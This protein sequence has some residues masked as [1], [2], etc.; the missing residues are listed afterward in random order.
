[1]RVHKVI[2]NLSMVVCV[3]LFANHSNAQF[4]SFLDLR[5]VQTIIE[6]NNQTYFKALAGNDSSLFNTLYTD[7]CWIM[8]PNA[9]IYCGPDAAGD[10]FGFAGKK[11]GIKNGKFITIDIYGIS[12]DMIAEVGFYQLFNSDQ[13]PFDDGKYIVL[14]KKTGN[15]WKRFRDSFSSSHTIK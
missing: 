8:A 12:N 14:W 2:F 7:D 9:S 4:E 10:Y 13:L 3:L 6:K 11:A 15:T 1:M 5:S